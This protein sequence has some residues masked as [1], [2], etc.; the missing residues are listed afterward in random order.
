M[1]MI[2]Y[3]YLQ[4]RR[5]AKASGGKKNP[6]RVAAADVAR[7]PAPSYPSSLARRPTDVRTAGEPPEDLSNESAKVVLGSGLI[8]Q[9]QKAT[10]AAIQIADK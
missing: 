8:D 2:A 5:L 1:T 3:A 4:T 9:S 10:A 6:Q 7:D